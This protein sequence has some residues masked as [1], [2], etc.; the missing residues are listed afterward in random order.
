VTPLLAAFAVFTS[1]LSASHI[2]FSAE[3]LSR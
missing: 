1:R 3:T 2:P